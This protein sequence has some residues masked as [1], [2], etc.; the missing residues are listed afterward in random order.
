[1]IEQ[2]YICMAEVVHFVEQGK[3][4]KSL[5]ESALVKGS[6]SLIIGWQNYPYITMRIFKRVAAFLKELSQDN[7]YAKGLY[8]QDLLAL[9]TNLVQNLFI[10]NAD[11]ACN[12]LA[13]A[14][15]LTEGDSL[16]PLLG[17]CMEKVLALEG[18]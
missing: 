4:L 17:T 8:T 5:T 11:F 1:M 18:N 14:F 3:L 15:N 16:L 2:A 12:M 6:L 7:D 9:V 10:E 13:F